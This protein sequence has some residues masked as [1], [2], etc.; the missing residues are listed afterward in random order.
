MKDLLISSI[1]RNTSFYIY[2]LF[3]ASIFLFFYLSSWLDSFEEPVGIVVDFSGNIPKK[4]DQAK[5]KRQGSRFWDH[6]LQLIEIR[7]D[8]PLRLVRVRNALVESVEKNHELTESLSGVLDKT[9]TE[10]YPEMEKLRELEKQ[11]QQQEF[12]MNQLLSQARWGLMV[13]YSIRQRA[14]YLKLKEIVIQK[15]NKAK[16]LELSAAQKEL[17]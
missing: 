1:K 11:K 12:E 13:E 7:I 4:L 9:I 16:E 8:E 15:L 6:Q 2:G 3:L 14:E 10:K 17:R 5:E